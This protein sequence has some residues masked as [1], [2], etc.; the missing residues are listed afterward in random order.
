MKLLSTTDYAQFTLNHTNRDIEGTRKL[1]ASMR[2]HG[3]SPASPL[4]IIREGSTLLVKQGHHRLHVAAKL[5]IPVWY[6]I[7]ADTMTLSEIESTKVAWSIAHYAKSFEREGNAHYIEVMDYHERTGIALGMCISML[8][9][10]MASSGNKLNA[11]KSGNYKVCPNKFHAE[12]IE[13]LVLTLKS[14]GIKWATDCKVVQSLS[15]V[16]SAGHA[17]IEQLKRRIMSNSAFITK[18][19]NIDQYLALWQE[20]YNR[21]SKSAKIQLAFLTEETI[22]Q[23]VKDNQFQKNS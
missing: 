15:R 9:G 3:F 18:M 12:T 20:I 10:E 6:V 17:D 19:H 11:F 4:H 2:K 21:N 13:I 7:C 23:R 1:E 5:G 8:G 14:A 22:R 16:V